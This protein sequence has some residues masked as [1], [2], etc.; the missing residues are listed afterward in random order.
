MTPD[1]QDKLYQE[2]L[3]RRLCGSWAQFRVDSSKS[4]VQVR[5][6]RHRHRVP[7]LRFGGRV[8]HDQEHVVERQSTS[9]SGRSAGFLSC[10]IA[11]ALLSSTGFAT[12]CH[13]I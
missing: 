9:C 1:G 4:G 10:A 6:S 12:A 8:P 3:R 5:G 2:F 11:R 7:A 13:S